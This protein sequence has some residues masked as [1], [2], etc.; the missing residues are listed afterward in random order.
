MTRLN[1]QNYKNLLSRLTEI[2]TDKSLL[3]CIS[4][5]YIFRPGSKWSN[6]TEYFFHPRTGQFPWLGCQA[7]QTILSQLPGDPGNNI[8][9]NIG[10]LLSK[11]CIIFACIGAIRC[12]ANTPPETGKCSHQLPNSSSETIE[13]SCVTHFMQFFKVPNWQHQEII[14]KRTPSSYVHILCLSRF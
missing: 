3:P 2:R 13:I 9:T 1:F 11:C 8:I 6:G 4:W 7:W 14:E 12:N 5:L 10:P